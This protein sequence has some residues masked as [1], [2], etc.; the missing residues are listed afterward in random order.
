MEKRKE[1]EHRKESG[2]RRREKELARWGET[3]FYLSLFSIVFFLYKKILF[4]L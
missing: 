2:T 3:F 1:E 4:I